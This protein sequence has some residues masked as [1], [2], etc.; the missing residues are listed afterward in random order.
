M[1]GFEFLKDILVVREACDNNYNK[2]KFHIYYNDVNIYL[3]IEKNIFDKNCTNKI[4][5]VDILESALNERIKDLKN[6]IYSYDLISILK[7]DCAY[8]IELAQFK[9]ILVAIKKSL[10][11]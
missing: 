5:I 1:K 6:D 4:F 2:C 3:E 8:L 7:D 11:N 10:T 9:N